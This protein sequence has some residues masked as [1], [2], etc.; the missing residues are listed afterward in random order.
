MSTSQLHRL[1]SQQYLLL[2]RRAVLSIP[3][4]WT[5]E[6]WIDDEGRTADP[7]T[8]VQQGDIPDGWI[9]TLFTLTAFFVLYK[10]PTGKE[11]ISGPDAPR[12]I[13]DRTYIHS[14]WNTS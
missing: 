5:G 9:F 12:M 3:P 4:L 13:H 14:L 10:A 11:V 6:G 2:L 1:R 8:T 7:S